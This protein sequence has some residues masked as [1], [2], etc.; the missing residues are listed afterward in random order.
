MTAVI[1]ESD[2]GR[3]RALAAGWYQA[4]AWR[5]LFLGWSAWR[6]LTVLLDEIEAR[7]GCDELCANVKGD[8]IPEMQAA[9]LLKAAELW[10]PDAELEIE[11][12][13]SVYSRTAPGASFGG[14][15]FIRCLNYLEIAK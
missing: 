9:G 7:E 8:S 13:S 14:A 1:A 5:R 4:S 10:G 12:T 15:V 6:D 2:L 11:E 3:L